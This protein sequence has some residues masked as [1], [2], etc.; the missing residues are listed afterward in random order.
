MMEKLIIQ[1]YESEKTKPDK[2]VTINLSKLDICIHLLP[3]KLKSA[4]D[5]EGIN[6]NNL[7]ELSGK[8]VAKGELIEVTSGKERLVLSLE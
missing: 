3:S 5:R 1:M 4:L 6:V 7:A 8:T 2:T